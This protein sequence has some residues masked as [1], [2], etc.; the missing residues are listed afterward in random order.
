[1][2]ENVDA[3]RKRALVEAAKIGLEIAAEPEIAGSF[4]SEI[5][6]GTYPFVMKMKV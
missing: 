5:L 3:L 4:I 1:M 2:L 6:T